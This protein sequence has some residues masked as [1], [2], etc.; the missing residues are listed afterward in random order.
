MIIRTIYEYDDGKH[1]RLFDNKTGLE[2][3]LIITDSNINLW[4]GRNE[5]RINGDEALSFWSQLK[6]LDY[7][8]EHKAFIREGLDYIAGSEAVVLKRE[9]I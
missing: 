3:R 9:K 7:G 2:Y 8:D 6:G 4:Y 5:K 1:W